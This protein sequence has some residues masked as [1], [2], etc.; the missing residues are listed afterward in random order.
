MI[1]TLLFIAVTTFFLFLLYKKNRFVPKHQPVIIY[2][3]TIPKSY[4][5]ITQILLAA[6]L[7]REGK[8]VK[9]FDEVPKI[10]T[11]VLGIKIDQKHLQNYLDVCGHE[12][13]KTE[14][15]SVPACYPEVLV[16][17]L[18]PI[19]VS[20][21][22]FPLSPLGLIHIKNDITYYKKLQFGDT[23]DVLTQVSATRSVEKGIE[24]D[25][26]TLAYSV[27]GILLWKCIATLLSRKKVT[28]K[29][30]PP[31]T[32]TETPK[33]DKEYQI[34]VPKNIGLQY[35][36][37]SGDYN[38]HHLYP[39]TAKLFG[40]RR[41]IA[42]GMWSLQKCLSYIASDY[43]QKFQYPYRVEASFKLP[44]FMPAKVLLRVFEGEGTLNFKLTSEDG[45]LPHLVGS[46][47]HVSEKV[48]ED[49]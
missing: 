16:F 47:S 4:S 38:P 37:V 12:K 26:E 14:Q 21:D 18:I 5:K 45:K 40:F 41:P 22:Q 7:K 39:L 1:L 20:A 24:V 43:S 31:P 6:I 46:I 33:V 25:L 32:E 11:K 8:L 34:N 49:S 42:H 2:N 35:A 17:S 44:V 48:P 3:K 10:T 27:N 23:L 30:A 9:G 36:A 28:G 13:Q 29:K 19:I 15:P